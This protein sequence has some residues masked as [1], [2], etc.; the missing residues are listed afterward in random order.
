MPRWTARTSPPSRRTTRYLPRRSTPVSLRP[1]SL[2]AKCFLLGW[3]RIERIPE[4][5]TC[6][7]RLPTTSFSRSRRIVSTSG[8]SGIGHHLAA[9]LQ[10]PPGLARRRLLGLLLGAALAG[11][12]RPGT[13]VH[14]GEEALGVVGALL[15]HVVAGQRV[16]T[17]RRQLLQS[18]LVVLAARARRRLADA[19]SQQGH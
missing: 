19:A 2:A 15:G 1:S 9:L 16:E 3:R 13:Q 12:A 7:M 4:T 5:S 14:G 10:G 8:S 18:R 11:A 6:L 17:L